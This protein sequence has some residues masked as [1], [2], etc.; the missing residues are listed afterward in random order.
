MADFPAG[1]TEYYQESVDKFTFTISEDLDDSETGVDITG[2]TGAFEVPC[3]I[4]IGDELMEVTA[5]SSPTLTVTRGFGGT[6]A[7]THSSGDAGYLPFTAE[8][9]NQMV[10]QKDAVVKYLCRTVVSLPVSDMEEYEMVEYADEIY[11]YNGSSWEKIGNITSHDDLKNLDIGDP[12]P[13]Y[14]TESEMETAH[15]ALSG[16]HVTDGDSHDHLEGAGAGRI[17]TH[18]TGAA[19]AGSPNDG[20]VSLDTTTGILYTGYSSSWSAVIGAPSGLIMPF[21]PANLSGACPDGWTRYTDL[22]GKFIKGTSLGSSTTGGSAT[23][24]HTFDATDVITHSHSIASQT[25]NATGNESHT[26]NIDVWYGGAGVTG[27][28]DFAGS[29][30][31]ADINT[32]TS[33]S[34]THTGTMSN[35]TES[36]GE[37]SPETDSANGEPPYQKVVWCQKD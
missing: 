33:G 24:L 36:T 17:R 32:T 5:K 13:V 35:D 4:N 14:Y 26:H 2:G 6:T 19:P 7:T 1:L 25:V 23:H 15:D 31:T 22:D 20:E 16:D 27:A 8:H 3:I 30:P 18:A 12:H 28:Y 10:A 29:T 11:I 21:D 37:A 9:Y 34:H